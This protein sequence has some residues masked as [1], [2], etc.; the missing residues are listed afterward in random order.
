MTMFGQYVKTAKSA[1]RTPVQ[2]TSEDDVLAPV[3]VADDVVVPEEPVVAAPEAPAVEEPVVDQFAQARARLNQSHHALIRGRSQVA[4]ED[5]LGE[6]PVVEEPVADVVAPAAEEP[7]VDAPVDVVPEGEP[8]PEEPALDVTAEA[9]PVVDVTEPAPEAPEAP[10]VEE[11]VVIEEVPAV[12]VPVEPVAEEPVVVDDEGDD[13]LDEDEEVAEVSP[14]DEVAADEAD[15]ENLEAEL[16]LIAQSAFA[17]ESYGVNPTAIHI[18]RSY[19]LLEGT[20]IS[21]L[22]LE[23]FGYE[24]PDH[25]ESQMALEALGEKMKEKAA[26]WS[27]KIVSASKNIGEKAM[28]VLTGLWDKI[29]ASST[30]LASA[31]WDKA[32]EA[33]KVV[34]AHPYKTILAVILAIGAA[35]AA[36]VFGAQYLPALSSKQAAVTKF[37]SDMVAKINGINWP[38]GSIKA[39]VAEGGAKFAVQIKNAGS[40][41]KAVALNKLDWTATMVK[42]AQGQIGRAWTTT[43]QGVS[44]FGAKA[45]KFGESIK[46]GA[47]FA[48][49]AVGASS[50]VVS[51]KAAKVTGSVKAGVAAGGLWGM[52]VVNGIISTVVSMAKLV[53]GVI[54]NGLRIISS[55]FSALVSGTAAAAA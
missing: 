38:F 27:A 14:E 49:D 34:K 9:D 6:E 18:M 40:T 22:G 26:Q 54:A 16:N 20:S 44:A 24:A 19:G 47:Q 48:K 5:A 53:Y 42:S 52:A 55:T 32:K 12:E 43:K 45:A 13:D 10:V 31:A 21:S 23:A 3:P 1:V 7:V 25:P 11:P 28:G 50:L 4:M 15:I 37:T 41:A 39:S 30:K 17:I 8:A 2:M 51:A 36:V 46:D 33:G 29:T 35:A